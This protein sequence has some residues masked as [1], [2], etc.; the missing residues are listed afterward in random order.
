MEIIRNIFVCSDVSL[1]LKNYSKEF[2]SKSTD[3]KKKE[4]LNNEYA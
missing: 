4:V 1:K 2:N 3:Q